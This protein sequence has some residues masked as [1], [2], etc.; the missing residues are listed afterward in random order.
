MN[1]NNQAYKIAA[2]SSVEKST[3]HP[4]YVI[5]TPARD[6]EP[7]IRFVLDS[8]GSQT[9]LPVEWIIVNDGSRDRTGEI[10]DQAASERPWIHVI[11]RHDRGFRKPG[12]GVMEAFYDGY[13]ALSCKDWEFIVKLDGDL[14]LA[15]DYFER[16][17][18]HFS[19]DPDLGVGGGCICH[20][21]SGELVLEANPSFHVRGATK[22][23][24]REC[25][26]AI[27]GLWPAP[28]WDTIDEVKANML[29]WQ[30]RTFADLRIL[31]HR[32]T[33]TAEGTWR[34]FVKNG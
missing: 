17:F 16:C 10:V 1:G 31:H 25:W 9:V 5:I 7:Y 11:H 20:D 21:K 33:G 6:E 27:G 22:I 32:R 30:T 19:E 4:A 2:A 24:K 23:Y 34:N 18:K 8:V 15:P 3:V 14:T 26:E 13:H 28:G 29:G 12:G